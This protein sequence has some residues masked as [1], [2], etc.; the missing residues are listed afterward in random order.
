MT[1]EINKAGQKQRM[2]STGAAWQRSPPRN[3]P[4]LMTAPQPTREY[5][6][7]EIMFNYQEIGQAK[8]QKRS[9]FL[10]EIEKRIAQAE[11]EIKDIESIQQ[12]ERN[13]IEEIVCFNER[14]GQQLGS[15]AKAGLVKQVLGYAGQLGAD[16]EETRP[17]PHIHAEMQPHA[18]N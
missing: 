11:C 13:H 5:T 18:I 17:A 10:S 1:Q 2:N 4:L 9:D 14:V 3:D 15:D 8:K 6:Q 12:E 16:E 7:N